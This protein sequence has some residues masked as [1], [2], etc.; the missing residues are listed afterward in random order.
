MNTWIKRDNFQ[1]VK[2]LEEHT[3][4][5]VSVINFNEIQKNYYVI[6]SVTVPVKEYSNEAILDAITTFEYEDLE[7]VK[8]EHPDSYQQVIAECIANLTNYHESNSDHCY[9][10]LQQVENKLFELYQIKLMN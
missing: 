3:F 6:K 10:G 5:V 7:H 1:W 4:Q 2:Q 8:E 9:D